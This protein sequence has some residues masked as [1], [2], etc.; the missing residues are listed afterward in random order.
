MSGKVGISELVS[1]FG[2]EQVGFQMLDT[3]LTHASTQKGTTRITF[4]T[5]A[6]TASEMLANEGRV[7]I[8]LW[9]ERGTFERVR[10]EIR[11]GSP[12]T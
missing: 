3:A 7:G 10:A 4:G 6:T 2:D 11:A 1:R 8:I 9:V 5:E 12:T